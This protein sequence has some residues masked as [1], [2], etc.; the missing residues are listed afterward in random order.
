M[1][2]NIKLSK[3]LWV[4]VAMALPACGG[5]NKGSF[6]DQQIC[7]A[8]IAAVMGRDPSIIKIDSVQSDITYLSYYRQDD[9]THWKYRCELDG[10]KVIWATDTGRWRTDQS[11]SKITLSVSGNELSIP[12]KYLDGSGNTK[13]Y[14]V[15]PLGS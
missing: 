7:I 4:V 2:I 11:D 6:T 8:T 5:Q 14:N 3:S 12:E 9:E 13:L 15:G 10:E 1:K